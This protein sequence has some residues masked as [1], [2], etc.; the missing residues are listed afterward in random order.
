MFSNVITSILWAKVLLLISLQCNIFQFNRLPF[1]TSMFNSILCLHHCQLH[2]CWFALVVILPP[3]MLKITT[4]LQISVVVS[5]VSALVVSISASPPADIL[6]GWLLSCTLGIR[7]YQTGGRKS[8]AAESASAEM[9]STPFRL[10][11]ISFFLVLF[12]LPPPPPPPIPLI[13]LCPPKE[14]PNPLLPLPLPHPLL[15]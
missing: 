15:G 13:P 2:C 11:N 1:S 8:E 7:Y 6:Q 14:D 10:L 4:A 5:I 12:L 9:P 3:G